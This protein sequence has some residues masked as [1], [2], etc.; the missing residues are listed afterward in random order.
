MHELGSIAEE[1]FCGST[2]RDNS[3]LSGEME[4]T[5]EVRKSRGKGKMEETLS[6]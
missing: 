1:K 4:C 5:R 2:V 3:T 6:I